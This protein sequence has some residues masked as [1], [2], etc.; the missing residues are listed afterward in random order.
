VSAEEGRA[1]YEQVDRVRRDTLPEVVDRLES[2]TALCGVTPPAQVADWPARIALWKDAADALGTFQPTA[3]EADLLALRRQLEPLRRSAANRM[4]ASISDGAYRAAKKEMRSHLK[5]GKKLSAP[6]LADALDQAIDVAK[7]WNELGPDNAAPTVPT[8]LAELE[9]GWQQLFKDLSDIFARVRDHVGDSDRAVLERAL[10]DLLAD[11]ATLGRLPELHRLHT[12]LERGGLG[13]L[14]SEASS[15]AMTPEAALSA[16][17][18]AW[19]CSIIDQVR[20]SDARVGAFDGRQHDRNVAEFQDLDRRHI[21][22]TAQRVRRLVAEQATRLQDDL[23]DQGA[24]I[25]DQA[26][27]KRGHLSVRQLFSGAPDVMT[28]LKPCWVMSPLVVSQLLP[29][30]QQYFDV[31]IFD[32]ASQVRPADAIPAILRGKRLV[33]AGDE[34][35]LPPTNFFTGP[36]PQVDTAE[37]E[38]RIVIDSGF[39]SILEGLLPFLDFRML[40][41]HYRSRDERLIAFSNVHLYDRGMTTFPGVS[42]PQCLRHELIPHVPG[43]PGTDVS[44]SAEVERVVELILEHAEQRP[45]E[46]LGVIAMGIKH[47]DRID[48]ALRRTLHHRPDL[49]EFFDESSPE[50]FFIKNL[51]RVQGDERDAIILTVGYGKTPDGRLLYRF[52]PLNTEGGERRLNVAITRARSTMT[53]VSSFSASDMDP[54][55]S[56]AR[57]VE[58]LRLYLAYAESNGAKL[59]EIAHLIPEL[60][61]FEVDVRDTLERAGVPLIAQYGASGYRID[62]AAKHPTQPGRMVLAVECDGASYHSSDTARDRDRLRQEHLERLGWTFHRIWSQDWFSNKDREI[63][64]AVT[65]YQNAVLHAD[66]VGTIAGNRRNGSENPGESD[67]AEH[68]APQRSA[69]PAVSRYL[70]ITA[71]SHAQLRQI[72]RWIESDTLLRTQDQ[73]LGEVMQDLG[74]QKRGKR[75][76]GAI[77]AAI[78]AE[79]G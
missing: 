2:A 22:T 11:T 8:N 14:L 37:L 66:G 15:R 16:F 33:V 63:A 77:E 24:L 75:I 35:Q 62:F 50:R 43:E 70:S 52:G 69:R 58:L 5:E 36:D 19:L 60:N 4:A 64:R 30:D 6:E 9:S 23:E 27:R 53:L 41:W 67:A 34:R 32:E 51:E 72:V 1:A 17:E 48:E 74:F 65:A 21:Q 31:T 79:R 56:S 73:L 49:D 57:G 76:V 68:T 20:L 12:N 46:T 71:Y 59:G 44:S 18:H 26:A 28:A 78:V 13:P 61:P 40:G 3:F 42:G 7:R 55:R 10:D 38:G 47:A 29:G 45:D 54:D 39:E 25:R